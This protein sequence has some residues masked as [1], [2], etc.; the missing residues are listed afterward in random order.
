MQVN[1]H[2]MCQYKLGLDSFGLRELEDLQLQ[3]LAET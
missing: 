1:Y 2:K 3:A